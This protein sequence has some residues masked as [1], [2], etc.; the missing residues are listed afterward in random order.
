MNSMLLIGIPRS[1]KVYRHSLIDSAV[2]F[3]V[4]AK[5][6][7]K[8]YLDICYLNVILDLQTNTQYSFLS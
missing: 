6:A 8:C 2:E 7:V 5:A 3:N 4:R 1:D